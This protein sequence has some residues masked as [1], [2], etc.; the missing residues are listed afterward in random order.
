MT[1]KR[2][3]SLVL[4]IVVM[5][6]VGMGCSRKKKASLSEKLAESVVERAI[7]KQ[8]GGKAQVDMQEGQIN[9]TTEEGEVR[10]SMGENAKLPADFPSDIVP[11][12]AGAKVMQSVST[13]DGVSVVLSS[14]DKQ[15]DILEF[16]KSRLTKDGWSTEMAMQVSGSDM[17]SL[18]K[19][20]ST[21]QVMLMAA[22]EGSQIHLTYASK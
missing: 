10:M 19:G 7:E 16:Y 6:S 15:A 14:K 5:S 21:L 11:I 12:Y 22:D 17:V 3:M 18:K 9:V 20:E 4:C 1:M 13:P 8:G 2:S